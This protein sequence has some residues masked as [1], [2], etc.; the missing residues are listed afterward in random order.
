MEL[1]DD[2]RQAIERRLE[3]VSRKELST[4]FSRISESYRVGGS[5]ASGLRDDKDALAYIVSRLPAT[6]AAV[7][8]ALERLRERAPAFKP[9]SA[10]DLGSGPGT[11]SWALAGLW[12][13][14]ESI[15]QVDCNNRFLRLGKI[16]S[17]SARSAAL[18]NA[19]QISADIALGPLPEFSGEIVVLSYTL[20]ELTTAQTIEAVISG[21]H[22]AM[23]VLVIVEPGTPAGYRRILEARSIL[24][25]HDARILAPCAHEFQCPLVQPDWC[26]FAQRISRTRD[27]QLVKGAPMAYEDEKFSYLVAVRENLYLPAE[28]SRILAHPQ[29]HR[30]GYRA[31]LCTRGGLAEIV[32]ISKSDKPL[33]RSVR[34]KGWGDELEEH[35]GSS[36][37]KFVQENSPAR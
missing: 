17:E 7:R 2:L 1:P 14:I 10:V 13:E 3:G 18:R 34:K 12:P 11:A 36:R 16:L 30:S 19:R 26:H 8:N 27:H 21:W 25:S 35:D 31:K 29:I 20:A 28:K 37:G 22:R 33:F 9:R 24:L 23:A 4:R 5:S 15:V 32:N 6:Y